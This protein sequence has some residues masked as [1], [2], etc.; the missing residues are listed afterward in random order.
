MKTKKLALESFIKTKKRVEN[1]KSDHNPILC[2]LKFTW[3]KNIK[4]Q[5]NEHYN[6]K[7]SEGLKKF[8]ITTS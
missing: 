3:N 1:K 2:K 4:K 7:N 5:R 6:L 8:K